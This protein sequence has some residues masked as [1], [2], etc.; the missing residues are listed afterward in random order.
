MSSSSLYVIRDNE[1]S[2]SAVGKQLLVYVEPLGCVRP[3]TDEPLARFGVESN[4]GSLGEVVHPSGP[5]A[6]EAEM[7]DCNEF[8]GQSGL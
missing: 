7:V 5:S 1:P 8:K 4:S 2:F 6:Q 3:F